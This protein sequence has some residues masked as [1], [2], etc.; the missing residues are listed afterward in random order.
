MILSD[1]GGWHHAGTRERK[2][3]KDRQNHLPLG[4]AT[5]FG[6]SAPLEQRLHVIFTQML[7]KMAAANQGAH[8]ANLQVRERPNP[9]ADGSHGPAA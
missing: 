5:F 8:G 7:A 6:S 3:R 9:H 2:G 4:T 1:G